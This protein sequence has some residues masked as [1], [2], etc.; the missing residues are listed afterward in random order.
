[1]GDLTLS[2]FIVRT[3]DESSNIKKSKIPVLESYQVPK[4]GEL[5]HSFAVTAKHVFIINGV[6]DFWLY[7]NGMCECDVPAYGYGLRQNPGS[8]NVMQYDEA[9][10][11][12][13]KAAG[14]VVANGV[15]DKT[16]IAYIPQNNTE[17]GRDSLIIK[18]ATKPSNP[19][20]IKN[21]LFVGDS[22]VAGNVFPK[23][24]KDQLSDNGITNIALIGRK[25][26]P[27]DNTVHYEATGG[28][29]W[30]DYAQNPN[31]SNVPIP[32]APGHSN[33]FWINGALD[34][35]AYCDTYCEGEYPDYVICNLSW[36]MFV[37]SSYSQ[38]VSQLD[39]AEN[40]KSLIVAFITAVRVC[41][42][43]AKIILNGMHHGCEGKL[44][45]Y[46]SLTYTNGAEQIADIYMDIVNNPTYSSFVEYCD[47][48]PYFDSETGM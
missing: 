36:N 17:I 13:I 41:S 38:Y 7:N 22:L 25:T 31:D 28:Y 5:V 12:K 42:P 19:T 18:C 45:I 20:T 37:N 39:Y 16:I 29:A 2:S 21:V 6:D 32:I 33:P 46:P 24:F 26:D 11:N 48:A 34:I 30:P 8:P 15:L 23:S 35:K 3:T 47:I 43:N 1:M 14:T 9:I 44:S 10:P 4:L 40:V 27:S